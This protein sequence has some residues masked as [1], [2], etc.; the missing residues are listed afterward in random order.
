MKSCFIV[1]VLL[2]VSCALLAVYVAVA[3]LKLERSWEY[4]DLPTATKESRLGKLMYGYSV[5]KESGKMVLTYDDREIC[6]RTREAKWLKNARNDKES[7]EICI[8]TGKRI[9]SNDE[10]G[11]CYD[12]AIASGLISWDAIEYNKGLLAKLGLRLAIIVVLALPVLLIC[13][14]LLFFFADRDRKL[15][16]LFAVHGGILV[17]WLFNGIPEIARATS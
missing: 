5:C 16:I 11:K 8:Q 3:S 10:W 1:Y 17:V 9:L 13:D 6:L 12:Q 7:Y 14:V 4:Y 2:Y 15:K